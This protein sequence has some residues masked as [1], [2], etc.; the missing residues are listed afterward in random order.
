MSISSLTARGV[1]VHFEADTAVLSFRG[2][3]IARIPR[4]GKLFALEARLALVEEAN[5]AVVSQEHGSDVWH[6]RLG[7]VTAKKQKLISVAY[8]DLKIRDDD[9]TGLCEGC[10][11]GKMSASSFSHKSGSVIKSYAPF[12][13]V[14]SDV[15]GPFKPNSKGGGGQYIVTFIDDFSRFVQVYLIASKNLVFQ[16]FVEFT[17][18]VK[19]QYRQRVKCIRTDNGGEYTSKRFDAFC[20]QEWIIHQ[21]SAPYSPQQNGLTERMNRTLTEMACSM[22]YHMQVDKQWWGEALM[23]AAHIVNRIPNTARPKTSPLQVLNGVKPSLQYLRVFGSR[24][25]VFVEKVKRSKLDAKAHRCIFLGYAEGSKAYRVWD[26]EEVT[27]RTV[28][29]DEHAP[30]LYTNIDGNNLN[31]SPNR[32]VVFEFDENMPESPSGSRRVESN[33]NDV[34]MEDVA[35]TNATDDMEVDEEGEPTALVPT[36]M[37]SP[38]VMEG[39][40]TNSQELQRILDR[41]EPPRSIVPHGERENRIAF[42]GVP[43]RTSVSQ[44]DR[45]HLLENG[46]A[47]PSREI[48]LLT[49]EPHLTISAE[50]DDD[51]S[52]P[53]SKRPRLDEYEIALSAAEVPQ[54]YAEAMTSSEAKYWKEVIRS[55]IRS[56]VRNHTW[57]LIMRPQGVKVIGSKWVFA[58][59]YNEKWEIGRYKARLV[60]LGYLQTQGIDYFHIYSPVASTNTIRVFLSVCCFKGLKIGQYDVETAFLNGNLTEVVYMAIPENIRTKTGMVCKLRRSLYGLKQ[61]AAVWY[62]TIR[63]VLK[64]MGFRE[65][66]ADPCM[67]VRIG[68]SPVYIILYVD[69]LLVGC[70]TDAEAEAICAELGSQFKLKSIGDARFVLGMEIQY[71]IVKGELLLR[72]TQ[73]IKYLLEKFGQQDSN[74]VRN[75]LI[76][77]QDLTQDGS[78]AMHRE[79]HWNAAIRVLCYL[80]GTATLGIQFR[81]NKHLVLEAFADA[82]WGGDKLTRRSTSGVLLLLG[83]APVVFKSKR[84][85]TVALSSAEAEYMSLALATQEVVWLR[86]LLLEMGFKVQKPTTVYLD[87]KSAISIASNH[88]YTPR[89][90]HID[91][92]AHFVRDHVEAKTILL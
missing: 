43:R 46:D 63:A 30:S 38:A 74:A 55:E 89:A 69:D 57:N 34:V 78:H 40:R 28:K 60:A 91:L 50:G 80:K 73:F 4:I 10:A 33:T 26:C 44:R 9:G 31:Y 19:T 66:R 68:K 87:N 37:N 7:H 49:S 81:R 25:Y 16:R 5:Q 70:K 45:P 82:N 27:T 18:L 58:Y 85:A 56:H 17:A 52:E 21:T 62:Q 13:I 86:Y 79:I 15:M 24:E 36:L 23:T 2:R 39:G 75:P 54:S 8:E 22:L 90:K 84:Q 48:P 12:E 59:K 64:K 42:F 35:E 6:A 41:P 51:V 47:A 67:F 83:G 77:G 76:I 14:H 3:S 92:R 72:Q 32:Q 53:E 65:C 1:G 88:G 20:R 61:A 29:L 11:K 71:N